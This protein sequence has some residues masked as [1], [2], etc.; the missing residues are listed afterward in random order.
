MGKSCQG[1]RYEVSN[2][3]DGNPETYWTTNDL[4][5]AGDLIIY[6]GA[7]TEVNRILLQ[8]YIKLGQ[9]VQEFKVSA[10][11]YST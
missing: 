3:N 7:E 5:T 9:R 4:Q 8:E 1:R 10:H 6:L 11:F 2:V